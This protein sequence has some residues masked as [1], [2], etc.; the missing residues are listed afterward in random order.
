MRN[1][2]SEFNHSRKQAIGPDLQHRHLIPAPV[3]QTSDSAWLYKPPWI[4]CQTNKPRTPMTHVACESKL[5]SVV[6]SSMHLCPGNW[7]AIGRAVVY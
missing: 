5:R 2:L 3:D 6:K 1:K 7:V 4:T